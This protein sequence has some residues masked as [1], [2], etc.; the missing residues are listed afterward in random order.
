MLKQQN[1]WV[2]SIGCFLA[3]GS[4]CTRRCEGEE[5][6]A[7]Q[8]SARVRGLPSPGC[9]RRLPGSSIRHPSG[10]YAEANR[11]AEESDSPSQ[12]R[13]TKSTTFT[14]SHNETSSGF[15]RPQHR[16]RRR[17]VAGG[18]DGSQSSD[19]P[20]PAGGG[21]KAFAPAPRTNGRVGVHRIEA[22]SVQDPIVGGSDGVF[23]LPPPLKHGN[24]PLSDRRF[25]V[26][27][28][29]AS[30]G[31][32]TQPCRSHDE[33]MILRRGT[34]TRDTPARVDTNSRHLETLPGAVLRSM[35]AAIDG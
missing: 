4:P 35:W 24:R 22:R 21:F 14:L 29:I 26:E 17:A 30:S 33:P 11:R 25:G 18:E 31:A 5:R 9:W 6:K 15:E 13:P 23:W 28:T 2:Y 19:C 20:R 32:R 10:G 16:S 7:P 8:H 34:P 3:R 27:Q 12:E 1:Y